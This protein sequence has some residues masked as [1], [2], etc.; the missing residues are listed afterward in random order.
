MTSVPVRYRLRRL[1]AIIEKYCQ[2]RRRRLRTPTMTRARP[3]LLQF[4]L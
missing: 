3:T 1:H 4:L 2:R